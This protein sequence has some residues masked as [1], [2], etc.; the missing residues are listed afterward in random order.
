M[1]K[2]ATKSRA[3]NSLREEFAKFFEDPS[4]DKLRDLLKN[5]DGEFR[6]LD[7]K[8]EWPKGAPLAKQLLGMLN[9]GGGCLVVGMKETD[10]G[11]VEAVGLDSF[12]DK[13]VLTNSVKSYIPSIYLD[14]LS[15]HEF[16]YDASE[17]G[18]IS[19]KKFQVAL[20]DPDEDHLPAVSEKSGEG[21]RLGAV[22]IR[23]EGLVEEASYADLQKLINQR[24]ERGHSTTATVDLRQ[25]L[26]QL[27]VLYSELPK[28]HS[29]IH[30]W[31]NFAA[32][33]VGAKNPDYPEESYSQF[34]RK[35]LD[36]K[37]EI[38]SRFIE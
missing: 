32:A 7:F 36:K 20:V 9:T 34:V 16:T 15:F 28:H 24:I 10:G 22:Y 14:A 21:I 27:K 1:A 13:A 5:H 6:N 2:Q 35:L 26:D 38:I 23:R 25:H 3:S 30:L 33:F 29:D 31:A 11:D 4:R 8:Q 12:T 17:Y 37:K 18:R 19:G